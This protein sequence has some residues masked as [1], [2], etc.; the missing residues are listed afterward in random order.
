MLGLVV[1]LDLFSIV[2]ISLGVDSS[3]ELAACLCYFS[4]CVG[5]SWCLLPLVLR[6]LCLLVDADLGS[7]VGGE[8]Q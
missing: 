1:I 2:I 4:V 7:R 5:D 8:R 6:S 3:S